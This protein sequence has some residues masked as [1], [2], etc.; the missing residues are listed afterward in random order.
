[1]ELDTPRWLMHYTQG[2]FLFI[3]LTLMP[4]I[5]RIMFEIW[6]FWIPHCRNS[7]F[8]RSFPF[9]HFLMES[10]NQIWSSFNGSILTQHQYSHS[11]SLMIHT[12]SLIMDMRNELRLTRSK[13]WQVRIWAITTCKLTPIWSL[14]RQSIDQIESLS[15][16]TLSK[17]MIKNTMMCSFK[18]QNRMFD[19]QLLKKAKRSQ[20]LSSLDLQRLLTKEES[21]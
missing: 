18:M 5:R 16:K 9:K 7:K 15:R 2:S 20:T 6:K 14:T 12:S 8:R 1:M 21:N 4:N 13:T 3:N 19:D 10:S 17:S 11:R